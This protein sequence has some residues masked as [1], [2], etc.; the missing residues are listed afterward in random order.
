MVDKNLEN[1]R[2]KFDKE[3]LIDYAP[4]AGL[5][6]VT[7][8]FAILTDGRSVSPL[9]LKILTNQVVITALVAI[10][11]VF[12]FAAG[13]LDLSAGGSMCLSVIVGGVVGT[14]TG[15]FWLMVITI[16]IVSLVIAGVKG[17]CAAYL[18]LPVFIVTIIL[19][20]LLMAL[21]LV[22]LDGR[23]SLALGDI[24]NVQNMMWIN[25]VFL[26]GFYLVALVLFNYMRIGKALK[27][28]GGNIVAAEQSG[29]N[30]K[31]S[32]VLAFLLS[33]VGIALAAIV[34]ALNTKTVTAATG[35]SVV[36]DV[37]VAVVLGGMP[38]SGGPKS[39]ISAALIGSATI[40]ILNNGLSI[41]NVS[42]DDIQI[43]RGVIFLVVVFITSMSY[44]TKYL[45]R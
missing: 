31:K 3:R 23:A 7:L 24:I 20:S 1:K 11:M 14:S 6:L 29:I 41:C 25:I 42:N 33:G 18:T 15:S 26:V 8:V 13:A 37:L 44:R 34:S 45:P 5:I 40:T 19:G 43:V 32:I 16:I 21:G 35:G 10:G 9:N 30:T 38:L 12:P 17:V 4:L 2:V 22:V 36:N 27:L 39:K 28:L